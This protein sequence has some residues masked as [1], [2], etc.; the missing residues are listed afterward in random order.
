MAAEPMVRT[1]SA[2]GSLTLSHPAPDLLSS[3]TDRFHSHVERLEHHAE[4]M[5]SN[6]SDIGEEIRKLQVEERHSS[7]RPS[8]QEDNASTKQAIERSRNASIS[9]YANS[10][11]DVNTTARWGGYSP[12]GYVTSP[13]GSIRS[14]SW[15]H[16]SSLNRQRSMSKN[17]LLDQVP[18]TNETASDY[19]SSIQKTPQMSASDPPTRQA[20]QFSLDYDRIVEDIHNELATV[21]SSVPSQESAPAA[22]VLHQAANTMFD[23]VDLP[24]RPASADTFQ[25]AQGAFDDFDGVHY[26]PNLREVSGSSTQSMMHSLPP[27]QQ[28]EIPLPEDGMVYYPAPVPR[29]LNMPQRLSHV[30]ESDLAKRKAKAMSSFVPEA[31]NSAMWLAGGENKPDNRKSMANLPPQLRASLYFDQ[32]TV[33]HDVEVDIQGE[34]AEHALEGI[35]DASASAPVSAFTDHPIAGPVSREVYGKADKRTS[36]GNPNSK[37]QSSATLIEPQRRAS[38]LTVEEESEKNADQLSKLTKRKSGDK[39]NKLQKRNSSQMSLGTMMEGD[40]QARRQTSHSSGGSGAVESEPAHDCYAGTDIRVDHE[41]EDDDDDDNITALADHQQWGRPT[42]L[43]AELSMR[44]AHLKNRNRSAATAFPD[45]AHSTL[46]Q[47]DAVAEI[48]KK[49]RQS[50]KVNL[51]WEAAPPHPEEDDDVPLGM[52]FPGQQAASRNSRSPVQDWDRPLGLLEQKELED[53]EPLSRRR[54]RLTGGAPMRNPS[55]AKRST[56]FGT[57]LPQID[58]APSPEPEVSA[59]HEDSEHEEEP[60]AA[61]RE[62]LRR[63][64]MLDQALGDMKSRPVSDDFAT[65][66]MGQF[67]DSKEKE[68]DGKVDSKTDADVTPKPAQPAGP[69]EEETLGQRRAR[70]RAEGNASASPGNPLRPSLTASRSLADILSMFPAKNEARRVS[71]DQLLDKLPRGSLLQ[72]NEHNKAKTRAIIKDGNSNR[73][74]SYGPMLDLPTP[75]EQQGRTKSMLHLS[76]NSGERGLLGDQTRTQT[77]LA[78]ITSIQPRQQRMSTMTFGA[79]PATAP[80]TPMPAMDGNYMAQP[81]GMMNMNM[82]MGMQQ[83]PQMMGMGMMMPMNTFSMNMGNMSMPNMMAGMGNMNMMP[84]QMMMQPAYGMQ[85]MGMAGMNMGYGGMGMGMPMAG[86]GMQ[87]GMGFGG[88]AM[89]PENTLNPE[90]RDAIDRWRQGIAP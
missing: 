78:A 75:R 13:K 19:D 71:D 47:L 2:E 77:G 32:T 76:S 51:A 30:P 25:Q 90:R 9:S 69:E 38:V 70:L 7:G 86:M 42:T 14:G 4:R 54:N 56:V 87:S 12:T 66:L 48:E 67:G 60:L 64:E 23:P 34:S 1:V 58:V 53:K 37:R 22:G 46:L 5:S 44:K 57:E 15:S 28:R 88:Q 18:D 68:S 85:G 29:V 72:R 89:M 84:N 41:S 6:G 10:I 26:N 83:N 17:S 79:A 27:Q 3:P 35:L 49:H 55:P 52:L 82:G 61:R 50:Q 81:A 45:G 80:Q 21:P 73:R 36:T 62:R 16:V 8:L 63:K 20:S 24:D 31:R 59:A 39:L 11:V 65:E 33:P 43:M 74:S 40:K